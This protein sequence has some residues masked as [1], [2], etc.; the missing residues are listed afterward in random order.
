[1]PYAPK[2]EQQ[3]REGERERE[4]ESFIVQHRVYK[5]QLFSSAERV[6][7]DLRENVSPILTSMLVLSSNISGVQS[8]G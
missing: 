3:E 1:M 2:W 8:A 7:S 5:R 4:R 6:K